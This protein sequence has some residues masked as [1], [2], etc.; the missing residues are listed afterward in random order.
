MNEIDCTKQTL[1][2]HRF[3]SHECFSSFVF[4][5]G[6]S[7]GSSCIASHV[8]DVASGCTYLLDTS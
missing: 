8:S 2:L 5:M 7:E 4:M 1:K 6:V 3:D